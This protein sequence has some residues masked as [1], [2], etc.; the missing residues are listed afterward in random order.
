MRLGDVFSKSFYGTSEPTLPKG[1]YPVIRMGNMQNGSILYNDLVFINL[2]ET[3]FLSLKLEKGDI[4]L[5]S[6]S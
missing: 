3:E 4:L 1:K 5:N 6:Q 2:N